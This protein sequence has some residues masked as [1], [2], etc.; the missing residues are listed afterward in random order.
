[1]K[2]MIYVVLVFFLFQV[3]ASRSYAETAVE[4]LSPELRSLLQQEMSA[5]EN[6]MKDIISAYVSGDLKTIAEI[7]NQLESSFILKQKLTAQQRSE[8]H[9]K[10]PKQFIDKDKQSH[11]IARSLERFSIDGNV[12][13]VGVYYAKL[14]ESCVSC[15]SEF[16][17]HRFPS[18][19]NSSTNK[20]DYYY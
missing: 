20:E 18:L 11:R 19:I 6:G 1:M 7:A 17:A 16:A 12:E 8:L 2:N 3:G 9:D 4:T 15:H 10:L 14:L 5:I 13:L